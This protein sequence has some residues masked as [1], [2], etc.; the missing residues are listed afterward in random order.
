[1]SFQ[2]GVNLGDVI[3]EG[4]TI[5]GDAVNVA[6]RLEMLAAPS[7]VVIGRSVFDH[8]K[9]KLPYCF[10][11]L[12]RHAVKNIAEPVHVFG[13]TIA[14]QGGGPLPLSEDQP[15]PSKP[16]VAVLS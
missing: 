6:A 5:Y 12:G 15:I 2:I 9:G 3:A 13:V 10:V 4:G 7:E 8:V 14:P 16:S 1:M 11:D